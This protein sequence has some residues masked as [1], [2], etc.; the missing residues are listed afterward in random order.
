MVEG[1]SDE[2]APSLG[3]ALAAAEG[4]DR[5]TGEDLHEGVVRKAGA[6]RRGHA[7]IGAVHAAASN[8][9]TGRSRQEI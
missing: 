1:V 5:D 7:P 3:D 6:G 4:L 8:L 2:V 9:Q